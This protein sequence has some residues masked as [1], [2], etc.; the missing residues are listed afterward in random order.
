MSPTAI[1]NSINA[2]N[3]AVE[4]YLSNK[5]CTILAMLSNLQ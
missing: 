4:G 2:Q 5:N 1:E 3:I